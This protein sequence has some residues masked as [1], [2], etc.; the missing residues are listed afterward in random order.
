MALVTLGIATW[1]GSVAWL[2]LTIAIDVS[3]AAYVTQ[4]LLMKQQRSLP[5]AT[6]VQ[7]GAAQQPAVSAAD[8]NPGYEETPT[9][10][11]IAG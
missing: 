10:R 6:V 2:W 4:L 7:I 8:S 9:V 11:V 5:R 1:M 3:I